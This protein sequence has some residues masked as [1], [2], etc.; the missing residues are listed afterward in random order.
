MET[1]KPEFAG[2]SYAEREELQEH[3]ASTNKRLILQM[4]T[5]AGWLQSEFQLQEILAW[6]TTYQ[7]AQFILHYDI[8]ADVHAI[9]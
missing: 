2:M 5:T 3:G 7:V 4:P 6:H 1:T 9:L 8:Q